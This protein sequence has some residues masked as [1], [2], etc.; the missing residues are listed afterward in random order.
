MTWL[1]EN[2]ELFP[3]PRSYDNGTAVINNAADE[4]C[5]SWNGHWHQDSADFFDFQKRVKM[6]KSSILNRT[7]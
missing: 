7:F 1:E 4:K 5:L 3:L 2:D 6:V